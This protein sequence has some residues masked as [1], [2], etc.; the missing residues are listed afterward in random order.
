MNAVLH[1]VKSQVVDRMTKS[2]LA[3]PEVDDALRI[4]RQAKSRGWS[5]TFGYWSGP[6][7]TPTSNAAVYLNTLHQILGN[8]LQCY[9]S[10]KLT[11]IN[12]DVG[13]VS[14]LLQLGS[15][16]GIRIHFDAMDPD[17]ANPTF[18]LLDCALKSY[19]NVGCTL[20]SRWKR[21]IDDAARL[22]EYGIPVRIVKGQWP[23]PLDPRR[24]PV[25]GYL[26]IVKRLSGRA[27]FVAVATHDRRVAR[28]ALRV[29]KDTKTPC[30]MEQLSSLP[31]NCARLAHSLGVPMRLYVPFGFAS[32]PYDI[33]QVRT[34]PQIVAWVLRDAIAGKHRQLSHN[35]RKSP[36]IR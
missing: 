26:E 32:L 10:I 4:Y 15:E 21:S 22:V 33:W 2:H 16:R 35:G 31:Q 9:L 28:A 34:R 25:S 30:E 17:S 7:D 8:H 18:S 6:E 24:D 23:D 12:Y 1:R 11:S 13:V 20:P 19:R 27:A 14:E 3:G 5:C 36:D 29:L